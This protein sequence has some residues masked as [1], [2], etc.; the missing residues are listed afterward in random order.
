MAATI[1][2]SHAAASH[3]DRVRLGAQLDIVYSVLAGWDVLRLQE[4]LPMNQSA[5]QFYPRVFALAAA[6]LLV[7]ALFKILQPFLG[8]LFWALLLAFLLF[9]VNQKLRSTLGGRRGVA[10]IVLTL[11]V[12]LLL[13]APATLLTVTFGRQASE[14]VGHLHKAA[15]RYQI[16]QPSDLL[17]IPILDRAIH[18]VEG[19]VPVTAEQIQGWMVEAAKGLLQML[20]SV[21]GSFFVG[22]LSVFVA[23]ALTLFFLFF[24]L[25]DGEVMVEKLLLLVPLDAER[26]AHL[27]E[28][29]SAVTQAVVLGALLTAIVQGA[30]VGIAMGLVRLPSPV[31]F[32][33]LAAVLSLV[34]LVGSSLVW[35]PAAIVLAVQGRYS[36]ALFLAAWGGVLVTFA[37]NAIRPLVISGRVRISTLPV[38]LGLMG[39][40]AAF[41]PIGMVLGPVLIA[42][43]L[44]LLRFAEESI[45]TE[46]DAGRARGGGSS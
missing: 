31:V 22:A 10:A 43:V 26:K 30:L 2:H 19:L 41:G 27:V 12:I 37:D 38:L 6:G 29:L 11:A 7:F 46:Q 36:A 9:P 18:M 40:V 14:L 13:V 39:G 16:V 44:A 20:V 24:F 4:G 42:L 34:P 32:G 33:V 21:S 3:C 5:S 35:A 25:R 28:H 15:A 45:L 17:R 23:L 1:S 8:A